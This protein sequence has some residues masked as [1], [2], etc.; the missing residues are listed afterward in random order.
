M[1]VIETSN[2]NQVRR[3]RNLQLRCFTVTRKVV[4]ALSTAIKQLLIITS[5]YL[6]DCAILQL[7]TEVSSRHITS[8][9]LSGGRQASIAGR[10]ERG[11]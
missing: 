10:Q 4:N 2:R 7:G 8:T 9:E 1:Q 6:S 5:E 11:N 3:D